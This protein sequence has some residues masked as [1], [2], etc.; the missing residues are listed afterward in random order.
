MINTVKIIFTDID[1]VLN[2]SYYNK[3][4]GG[5]I[6]AIDEKNVKNLK[7]IV[8]ICGAKVVIVSR[9]NAFLGREFDKQR[10]DEIKRCGVEP[11]DSIRDIE[12]QDSKA[13]AIKRWLAKHPDVINYV[14]IDDCASDFKQAFGSRFIYIKGKHGLSYKTANDAIRVLEEN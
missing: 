7:K 9:A 1:G 11:I 6:S 3:I 4:N 8:D 10:V 12:L 14:V 5:N 2:S 13:P